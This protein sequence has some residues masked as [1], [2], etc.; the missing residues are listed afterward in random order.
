VNPRSGNE[1][2]CC[3]D[4]TK[5][6]KKVM[7]VG[8]GPA[9][10]SAAKICALRGHDVLLV[11]KKQELG[12]K[13]PV[14]SYTPGKQEFV[15]AAEDLIRAVKGL[16]NITIRT[17]VDADPNL[18]Q[19]ISPDVLVVAVGSSPIIP[20]IEGVDLENVFVAENVLKDKNFVR[21]KVIVAGGGLIGVETALEMKERG[22]DVTIVELLPE[23]IKDAGITVKILTM[24]EIESRGI[25]ILTECRLVRINE[26]GVQV[27]HLG[28][29][30][31]ITADA[32]VLALGYRA[33]NTTVK[34][35]SG[36]IAEEYVIGDALEAR[37]GLEAISE[38]F[39]AALKI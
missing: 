22:A 31:E 2:D 16:E 4:Q 13:I 26:K 6:K 29:L 37:R 14:A 15:L 19:E 33:N 38:G 23:V 8:G 25:K 24:E 34:A 17:S 5:A 9:G 28:K 3:I 35:L 1:V 20:R 18:V 27:D 32:V 7:V 39:Y 36:I 10:L 21:G 12:G 30:S 11:E